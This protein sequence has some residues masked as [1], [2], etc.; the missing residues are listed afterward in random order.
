MMSHAKKVAV[1]GGSVDRAAEAAHDLI[2]VGAQFLAACDTLRPLAERLAQL[3]AEH[4]AA[5]TAAG[6]SCAC[7]PVR[8]A[9]TDVALAALEPL[10]PYT[11]FASQ[12]VGEQAARRLAT[13]CACIRTDD[14]E[15]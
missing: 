10:R 12:E 4:R 9:A 1:T 7:V 15:D 2:T 5:L 3:E 14:A 11:P 6:H 13:P 8:S